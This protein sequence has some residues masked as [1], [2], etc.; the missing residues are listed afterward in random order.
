MGFDLTCRRTCTAVRIIA[1]SISDRRVGAAVVVN[2]CVNQG[3]IS[4]IS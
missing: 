3:A 4:I 1:D 2:G